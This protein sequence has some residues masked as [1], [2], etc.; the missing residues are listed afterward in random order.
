MCTRWFSSQVRHF[1]WW[2]VTLEELSVTRK[3][4]VSW[5]VGRIVYGQT[6]IQSIQFQSCTENFPPHQRTRRDALHVCRSLRMILKSLPTAASSQ[7]VSSCNHRSIWD[8][9]TTRSSVC[10]GNLVQVTDS[11]QSSQ[12]LDQ[13]AFEVFEFFVARQLLMFRVVFSKIDECQV[14]LN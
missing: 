2:A 13:I 5:V 10:T 14:L 3:F 7:S 12:L 11:S 6:R 9:Q 4:S 8:A 1:L